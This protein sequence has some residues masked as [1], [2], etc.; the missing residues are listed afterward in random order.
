M[1]KGVSFEVESLGDTV[2]PNTVSTASYFKFH[3][4]SERVLYHHLLS[5]F[6]DEVD[7][8]GSP[9]GFE[10]AGPRKDIFFQGE[11]CRAAILTCGGLCPGLNAVIRGVVLQLW[12]F[13]HCKQILGVRYGYN[14][15]RHDS[16]EI[17]KLNPDWVRD[18][19]SVGGTMLGT[20]RGA[21]PVEE[22]VDKLETLKVDMLFIIGGDGSMRG[23]HAIW[24][25]V[26][27][28]GLKLAVIG[29]PKTIDNDIPYVHRSFG[30]ETAVKEAA[31]VVNA[32][33]VE[34]RGAPYGIGLVKLMGRYSG[35]ITANAVLASG[36][37]D[38][39]LIPESPFELE[40]DNGLFASVKERLRRRRQVVIVV[41]EG[42]GQ[43]FFRREELIKDASGNIKPGDIGAYLRDRLNAH[44][45]DVGFP[46]TL[47]YIDP[48]YI[49]RSTP[50]NFSDKIYCDHLARAAVHAAMAGKGGML[51]GNWHGHLT[52]VP[53][54]ALEGE[55]R[56][57]DLQS[58][59]W[60]SVLENTRQPYI[61]GPSVC[62]TD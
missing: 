31:K 18:I 22:M 27:R 33:H 20:S 1:K 62:A 11:K 36:N 19:H 26:R 10:V 8:Q 25:E 21:P 6:Q 40:G 39:C 51:V 48:S 46:V 37:A 49:I 16:E 35:Y 57:V 17:V 13:Y 59:F 32:A 60:F 34:S 12:Y 44:F 24:Q 52:H 14:G 50:P 55:V 28:R 53:M 42:A 4:D 45:S 38:F 2:I 43:Q 23:G 7:E 30:Y 61:I 56:Q 29:V 5:K 3:S 15:L 58:D 41:A 47:K 54:S 9:T